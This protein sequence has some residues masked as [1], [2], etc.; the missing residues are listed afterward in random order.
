VKDVDVSGVD[1]IED[2]VREHDGVAAR[3]APANSLVQ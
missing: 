1:E 2:A 3:F